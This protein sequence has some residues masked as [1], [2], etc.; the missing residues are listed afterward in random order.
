MDIEL[1][2]SFC[3]VKEFRILINENRKQLLSE[4]SRSWLKSRYTSLQSILKVEKEVLLTWKAVPF[5]T[6]L[7][8]PES[9]KEQSFFGTLYS[10]ILLLWISLQLLF[11]TKREKQYEEIRS[12]Y[13][14]LFTIQR[15]KSLYLKVVEEDLAELAAKA[16]SSKA[17]LQLLSFQKTSVSPAKLSVIVDWLE[18]RAYS[19]PLFRGLFFLQPREK[20][21]AKKII[22]TIQEKIGNFYN[23]QHKGLQNFLQTSAANTQNYLGTLQAYDSEEDKQDESTT[24]AAKARSE[25]LVDSFERNFLVKL[26]E[27]QKVVEF[28]IVETIDTVVS[29]RNRTWINVKRKLLISEMDRARNWRKQMNERADRYFQEK[30]EKIG[31]WVN[32]TLKPAM[33]LTQRVRIQSSA[34]KLDERWLSP[35]DAPSDLIDVMLDSQNPSLM[36]VPEPVVRILSDLRAYYKSNHCGN[37]LYVTDHQTGSFGVLGYLVR[38]EFKDATFRVY[39]H[40]KTMPIARVADFSEDVLLFDDFERLVYLNER[41]IHQAQA[42]V[43]QLLNSNKLTII[44]VHHAVAKQLRLAVPGFNRFLFQIDFSK[45]EFEAFKN[46]I[47]RRMLVTG[48]QFEYDDENEF[49]S[50]LYQ[51]SSGL[52]GVGLRLF[53][54]CVKQVN[55]QTITLH[56]DLPGM[57]DLLSRLSLDE[58]LLLRR[59]YMHPQVSETL[60]EE[61]DFPNF[62]TLLASMKNMGILL[63]NQKLY[64]IRPEILGQLRDHLVQSN[65]L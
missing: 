49:W 52:P 2:T 20:I 17:D 11:L 24:A 54:K 46:I 36:I 7:S 15:S 57:K 34:S 8:F 42:L 26:Q 56:Y 55:R 39:R 41:H 29:L 16:K 45:Y 31:L 61:D 5:S 32:E 47:S 37:L 65:L 6:P 1:S 51:A 35:P 12:F 27:V 64:E 59:I 10:R 22:T 63:E 9:H 62:R 21:R 14:F 30:E 18:P 44:S 3:H 4:D 38:K 28:R 43:Q 13:Y 53:L 19:I 40:R 60:L 50:R 48:Y 33:G 23:E 25:R 58:K